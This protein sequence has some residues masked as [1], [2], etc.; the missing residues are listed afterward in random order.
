MAEQGDH[1]GHQPSETHDLVPCGH[2][3]RTR[4]IVGLVWGEGGA[5]SGAQFGVRLA[6]VWM[7]HAL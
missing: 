7:H 6:V 3:A 2:L 5:E 4:G 1:L